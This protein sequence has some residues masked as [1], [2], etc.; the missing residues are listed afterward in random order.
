MAAW[1][2]LLRRFC[3]LAANT[4]GEV[5]YLERNAHLCLCVPVTTAEPE[6]IPQQ[7]FFEETV[8]MH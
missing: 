2:G 8:F 5:R 3:L 1:L 6:S 7:T 4:A